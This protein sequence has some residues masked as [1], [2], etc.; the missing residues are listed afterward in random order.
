M[1]LTPQSSDRRSIAPWLLAAALLVCGY[2]GTVR[3]DEPK[4]E[5]DIK[6]GSS[7]QIEWKAKAAVDQKGQKVTLGNYVWA[8]IDNGAKQPADWAKMTA[9]DHSAAWQ[10]LTYEQQQNIIFANKPEADQAYADFRAFHNKASDKYHEIID[11]QLK[12]NLKAGYLNDLAKGIEEQLKK[13][14]E[15]FGASFSELDRKS[16]V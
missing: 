13:D 1:T 3:A 11:S 14:K 6:V 4:K 5:P 16:V 8:F 12:D 15:Q 10:K 9:G 2:P 7:G